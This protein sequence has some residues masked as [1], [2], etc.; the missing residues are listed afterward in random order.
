MAALESALPGIEAR[1][2]EVEEKLRTL[3]KDLY[4]PELIPAQPV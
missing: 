4:V 1:L 2:R 3:R